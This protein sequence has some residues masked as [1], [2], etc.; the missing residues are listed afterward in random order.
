MIEKEGQQSATYIQLRGE[1]YQKTV[2]GLNGPENIDDSFTFL[3]LVKNTDYI[4]KLPQKISEVEHLLEPLTKKGG[5]YF[6]DSKLKHGKDLNFSEAF[7][8]A[9][10][11]FSALNYPVRSQLANRINN[12]SSDETHLLQ[13]TALL[14][15][16]SAKEGFHGLSSEEIAGM[17][18]ATIHLDTVV[19]IKSDKEITAFGGMGGD[20]GYPL[21]GENSK[22][23]SLSTL[24][25]IVLSTKTPVHKHH[26]YPNTSK[27]AGQSAIEA[28]GARSDF[29]TLDSFQKVL[30][31]TNLIMTSCH[32]TRTLHTLS[33]LLKGETI[34]HV[35]GPLSFTMSAESSLNAMVGVNEKIHP[36]IIS[37]ALEILNR[38]GFQ[39]YNNSAVYFGTD[40]KNI[41]VEYLNA[42]IYTDSPE[43]KSHIA[44][45]EVAP[46]PYC[47][48]AAFM[49]NGA[50]IGS[51][52][53]EPE[54]FYTPDEL[55]LID[56]AS[57]EI[58][59]S[60]EGILTAN[61]Q[62]LTGKDLSKS[63]YLAMTTGLGIFLK[64]HINKEDAFDYESRRVN[65]NYLRTSTSEAL[66]NIMNGQALN[67]CTPEINYEINQ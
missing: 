2:M 18:A 33:H 58:P 57:L 60:R 37:R 46:P 49:L 35:I 22:L 40:L 13:A 17:V 38:Q 51:F 59:N 16:M 30:K 24:A 48:V 64:D 10:F 54:D 31:D 21:N 66:Q 12:L 9:T 5:Y 27:V 1:P 47:T 34:N 3:S 39:K 15:S 45:D 50:N 8:L 61:H 42:E 55:A 44:I 43:L 28:Y 32:N 29:Y 36:E 53:L 6:I 63:M 67:R 11:V 65:I 20:R 19:R 41:P 14:S 52:I 26:S 56:L 62:A 25:A 23:F 4:N 7:S